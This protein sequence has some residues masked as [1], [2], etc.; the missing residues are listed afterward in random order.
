[1]GSP[2]STLL[3]SDQNLQ[4]FK[5]I[6]QGP[7]HS[8][9]ITSNPCERVKVWPAHPSLFCSETKTKIN[10]FCVNCSSSE[11]RHWEGEIIGKGVCGSLKALLVRIRHECTQAPL[12]G[13]VTIYPECCAELELYNYFDQ[14]EEMSNFQSDYNIPGNVILGVPYKDIEE[15]YFSKMIVLEGMFTNLHSSITNNNKR[16]KHLIVETHKCGQQLV[17]Y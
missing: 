1:M 11:E 14:I 5:Q 17:R 16:R 8:L 12:I 4:D 3:A 6:Q 9:V 7:R 10:I 2:E 15:L 13:V